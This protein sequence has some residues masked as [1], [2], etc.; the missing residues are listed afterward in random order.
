MRRCVAMAGQG[1]LRAG[2]HSARTRPS[3]RASMHSTRTPSSPA[4]K[5]TYGTA[6]TSK[7]TQTRARPRRS[8]ELGSS[9]NPAVVPR[10]EAASWRLRK[11]KPTTKAAHR[12]RQGRAQPLPPA[13]RAKDQLTIEDAGD[14]VAVVGDR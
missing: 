7:L 5:S 3:C 4:A 2:A 9:R 10:P 1:K 12:S 13:E 11:G 14:D 6:L 8:A